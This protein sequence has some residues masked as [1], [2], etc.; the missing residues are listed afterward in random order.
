MTIEW[1]DDLATGVDDIDNQHR[2]L[3]NKINNLL[4]AC[5]QGKGKDEVKK[6]IQFLDDYVITHF[7]AEEKYMDK[8]DYPGYP[9]HRAQHQEFM[10]NFSHL[11]R[12]FEEEGVGIYLVLNTNRMVVDWLI[13]HIRKLDRSLGAFLKSK[14]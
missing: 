12:Q 13:N 9:G 11:K 3:F 10:E 4:Q 2:E 1:T 5:R 8:Y 7:S 6:V 14:I